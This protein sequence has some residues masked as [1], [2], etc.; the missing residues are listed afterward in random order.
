MKICKPEACAALGREEGDKGW[1]REVRGGRGRSLPLSI[2][3][4][5][6]ERLADRGTNE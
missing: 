5:R 2:P 6:W 4:C 3:S 1:E